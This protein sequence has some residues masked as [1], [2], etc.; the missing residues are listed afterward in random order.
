MLCKSVKNYIWGLMHE[1]SYIYFYSATFPCVIQHVYN[2]THN[3]I[4]TCKSTSYD[5]IQANFIKPPKYSNNICIAINNSQ[6]APSNHGINFFLSEFYKTSKE[7]LQTTNFVWSWTNY[8][9]TYT[10]FKNE[11]DRTSCVIGVCQNL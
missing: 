9:Y 3:F 8:L 7:Q 5:S 1:Q 10:V 6:I 11:M 4:D 2:S